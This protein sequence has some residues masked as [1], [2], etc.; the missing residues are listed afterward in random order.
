MK[1]K[2]KD[3]SPKVG[4]KSG[5]MN[6]EPS[7]TRRH[8]AAK[9]WLA[10]DSLAE[11][12]IVSHLPHDWGDSRITHAYAPKTAV[13][14]RIG[15]KEKRWKSSDFQRFAVKVRTFLWSA[16]CRIFYTQLSWFVAFYLSCPYSWPRIAHGM[17]SSVFLD[18]PCGCDRDLCPGRWLSVLFHTAKIAVFI[19]SDTIFDVKNRGFWFDY[20][21]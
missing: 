15:Q 13:L 18:L 1:L 6:P 12:S 5:A 20:F 14:C 10:G 8:N 19:G 2:I 17:I 4:P 7:Q 11:F 16:W 3:H 9:R 21:N